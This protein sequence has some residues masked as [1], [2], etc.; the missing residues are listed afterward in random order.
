M[1]FVTSSR[2]E[3]QSP[4]SIVEDVLALL[5]PHL[6]CFNRTITQLLPRCLQH[7]DKSGF[8]LQWQFFTGVTEG[9]GRCNFLTFLL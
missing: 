4:R 7:I 5:L 2:I 3:F 8:E 9:V 1:S 6:D